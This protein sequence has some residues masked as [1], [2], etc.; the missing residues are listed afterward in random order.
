MAGYFFY[1]MWEQEF[2]TNYWLGCMIFVMC[3]Y[4]WLIAMAKSIPWEYISPL[5]RKT[6]SFVSEKIIKKTQNS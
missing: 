6:K 1:T 3:I 5:W 2:A 4:M